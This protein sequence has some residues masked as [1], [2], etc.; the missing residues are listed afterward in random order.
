MTCETDDS[1]DSLRSSSLSSFQHTLCAR[2]VAFQHTLGK[3]ELFESQSPPNISEPWAAKI[4]HLS[5][6]TLSMTSGSM[7]ESVKSGMPESREFAC[8]NHGQGII[9]CRD[10]SFFEFGERVSSSQSLEAL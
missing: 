7:K 2:P 3:S 4:P 6:R 8:V 5:D 10:L 9:E 1:I